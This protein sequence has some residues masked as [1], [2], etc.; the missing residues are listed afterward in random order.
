MTWQRNYE[1][2]SATPIR[3]VDIV[4]GELAWM[5]VRLS[6]VATAF[7]LVMAAFG[8]PQSA[9]ALLAVP[10][11]VLTGLAFAAPVIAYSGTQKSG[12]GNAFNAL[13]RFIITPLFLFSGIFFPISRLPEPLESVAR[14]TPLF[15]GVA[16]T[17]GL[18]L[19][20]IESP[21]WIAHVA[22]L[23]VLLIAGAGVAVHTFGRRLHS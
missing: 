19:G 11:A 5:A 14:F 23:A 1:A 15:H 2:I 8:V 9:L 16:L 6:M 4:L 20:T 13:F 12:T 3:V 7:A 17:R 21:A 22:Y 18:T 10:A